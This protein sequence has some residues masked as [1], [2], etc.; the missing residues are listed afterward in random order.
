MKNNEE[1]SII[2]KRKNKEISDE[3][4]LGSIAGGNLFNDLNIGYKMGKTFANPKK[5]PFSI[6][7]P[8][9]KAPSVVEID[10]INDLLK[11]SEK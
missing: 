8:G 5:N 9:I 3:T 10:P 6:P 7:T 1:K 4:D 2:R 11:K